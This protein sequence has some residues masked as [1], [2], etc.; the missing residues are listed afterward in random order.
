[1]QPFNT[2]ERVREAYWRYIE[3]SYPIR[4]EDL[5][6]KFRD[7]VDHEK[8]LWQEPFISLSRPFFQG[9][10]LNAMISDGV[11]SPQIK[12]ANWGFSTLWAHQ[13]AAIKQLSTRLQSPVNTI[14]ATGT[15]SGKTQAFLI[16]I[17][18]DCMRN[19]SPA[20]VRAVILYPMNALVNDQ[21]DRLRKYL[22][23]AGVTFGRYTGDTPLNEQDAAEKGI[24]R[25]ANSPKEEKYTRKEIQDSPPQILLTNYVMLE[26]LLLRKADQK[27]FHGVKPRYLVLDEVHTYTGILGSEVA[28]LIRRFKEHVGIKPDEL[29]CVGTSAT[30]ISEQTTNGKQAL[31]AFASDLF[32]EPFN[33]NCVI[34]EEYEDVPWPEVQGL[35]APPQLNDSD[36]VGVDLDNSEHIRRLANKTIG[37][38][39]STNGTNVFE[40][41]YLHTQELREFAELEHLLTRPRSL[42][43]IV[44]LYRKLEGRRNQS[45][46]ALR[47]EV[48]A[49]LLL[50]SVACK[51]GTYGSEPEA[52]FRPK[53]HLIV[54]SLTP[55]TVCLNPDCQ[56]L[57]TDGETDCE[58]H[59]LALQQGDGGQQAT[60]SKAMIL[61]LCR[62]CGTDYRI[63]YFA[64]SDEML[65]TARGKRRSRDQLKIEHVGEVI[66]QADEAGAEQLESIFLYPGRTEDLILREEDEISISTEE[67]VICPICLHARPS[68]QTDAVCLNGVCE[69]F[70]RGPLPHF[71]AF[72]GGSRCPVCQ[73]QGKGRRPEII[74]PLRSGAATSV[75]VL[76]QSLF[77]YLEGETPE[78]SSEKRILI[79][80]DSRQDTAHQA[81][82]L[83]DR[84]QVFTQR[85]IVYQTLKRHELE[86]GEPIPLPKLAEE[87]FLRTR[88]EQ[89]E[90]QAMNLL[91]PVEYRDA[92]EMGFYEEGTTISRNEMNQAVNRLRWDLTVEF[93]DRATS[94]YSLER[95]GLTTV[96]YSRLSETIHDVLPEFE[97][98][99]ISD[100]KFLEALF[101]SVLDYLRVR[102]AV[103][104]PPFREYLDSKSTAVYQ[105]I[106]Y[107]TRETRHPVGFDRMKRIKPGAYNVYSWYNL[108][109]PAAHQSAI[110]N[111]FYR[112][113]PDMP[114][115]RLTHLIDHMV[116]TLKRR[117]YLQ[118][119]EIGKLSASYGRISTQAVQIAEQFLEVTTQGERY[120]CP[121]CGQSRGFVISPLG[122][123][124]PICTSYRCKGKPEYYQPDFEKN[125]YARFYAVV[126]P[127]RL[128]P[129]EHSGQLSNDERVKVEEKFK[130]GLVNTLVCTPTLE[131]GVDIGDLVSLLMRNIPPTPSNYAQRAGRAGRSRRVALILS[132]AGSGPHDSHH[133]QHPEEMITGQIKPP[134]FLLDNRVVIDR[135]LNSLILEK[136]DNELPRNWDG[137]RT[138]DGYLIEDILKPFKEEITQHA[139]DIQAA[140]AQAFVRERNEGGLNWLDDAY[141]QKQVS[142]FTERLQAGLEH[143]CRRYREIYEELRKSRA[144]I[145][146]TSAEQEN[147]RKL[148][149]ALFTLENDRQYLPLSYLAL[150]GF[151]PRYGFPGATIT[152]RDDRQREVS[153]AAK[154]GLTEYAPG[155]IVYVSGRKLRIQ[156]IVF[157]GG[158][159][160]DPTQNAET[161][162]YCINCD[163]A[164]ERQLDVECPYCH[165]LLMTGRYIDFEAGYGFEYEFITQEDEYRSRENYELSTYLKPTDGKPTT[166]D[167]TL[168]FGNWAFEYSRLRQIEIF[169]RGLI[170]QGSGLRKPFVICL[171][172]GRWHD[173]R[174]QPHADDLP[175]KKVVGHAP[176]CTV[177]TWDPEEDPRIAGDLHLRAAIQ[178]DVL[179]IRLPDEVADNEAWIQSFAQALKLGM[180]LE[181]YVGPHELDSFVYR[182]VIDG[183]THA[184]LVL[185]DTMPGGT[186]YLLRLVDNIPQIAERV[187]NHLRD[188]PCEKAC[189]RCLKEFWNQR[190]HSLLD[191]NIVLN[192]LDELATSGP[193]EILPSMDEQRKFESFLEAKFYEL[194]QEHNLPLPEP[195]SIV[196]TLDGKYIT[197]A[198][199]V[200]ERPSVVIMTD[201]KA[202]HAKDPIAIIEDLD[203]RNAISLQKKTLLEFTYKD[204]I[205]TPEK[206][207]EVISVALVANKNIQINSNLESKSGTGGRIKLFLDALME[208]C[209]PF[210]TNVGIQLAD[211][212]ELEALAVDPDRG[213]AI[214]L[215]DPDQW[216]RNP[217]NW[218]DSLMKYNLARIQGWRLLRLPKPWLET[219]QGQEFIQMVADSPSLQGNYV[220]GRKKL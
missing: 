167:K 103:N 161:Y 77:P 193:G 218:R 147:E 190:I 163:Y 81:G 3:T 208:K 106:A 134:M 27:I 207:I 154:V 104:Y 28:C 157:P 194:L 41:L 30:V 185:Y 105:R 138:E 38:Q 58:C 40:E 20:G 127:E 120:R 210:Q 136:L 91:T 42:S 158:T 68:N 94:R 36:L 98:F 130:S 135:H 8:L 31:T 117:S 79:F 65:T 1:M 64:V 152:V 187:R 165:E 191:K 112:A 9:G 114:S 15:G 109:S 174:Q 203:R 184:K 217:E 145:R 70:G 11:L 129:V 62:S 48:M 46:E 171:E 95:E 219:V 209:P 211:G 115:Q 34:E 149:M 113:F 148:S 139:P 99:G 39:L 2:A 202:F 126:Q 214:V 74:T 96:I 22:A 141:V 100:P 37:V 178:G 195:Q 29:I 19:P 150:V 142:R 213:I 50:G 85:Q 164:T 199:F 123:G 151:L 89:G 101:Q 67:Y 173:S 60:T 111:I 156:R 160:D 13:T 183:N 170:E 140:V 166:Q 90:I 125:F 177:T 116:E 83:R 66:L 179:E 61:G 14:V 55:L 84:H 118:T 200:Y 176:S 43:S 35:D 201:G 12:N 220:T 17:V 146:P 196:R 76:A 75:A 16:P 47:N 143:W 206:V 18:D 59:P 197:R 26:L 78:H 119:V 182:W 122:R 23:G 215:I 71:V 21:L 32:A 7:L 45:A 169:N 80:A 110:Y 44:D 205:E 186:G 131:L 88:D 5:K 159:K 92:T 108:T 204:V 121:T 24:I 212:E 73:A 155:N 216:V 133:F 192:T 82:Y 86:K 51:P 102:Q 107:P 52:R 57:H 175:S 87:V 162:R 69:G 153:Q 6:K 49:L 33:E 53:I 63:G 72:L 132:H 198:D 124:E 172:C 93:T 4:S 10:T 181:Y 144:K 189:Y 188:C 168:I 97:D 137:I 128:Y 56:S 25:P 54:R 180:Q